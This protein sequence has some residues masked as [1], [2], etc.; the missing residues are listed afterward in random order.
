MSHAEP[1]IAAV[2]PLSVSQL[3]DAERM[4]R[5]RDGFQALAMLAPTEL[6]RW[7][8]ARCDPTMVIE[9]ARR[10]EMP[11]PA[12]PPLTAVGAPPTLDEVEDA[13]REA[14]A[15]SVL[16]KLQSSAPAGMTIERVDTSA[17]DRARKADQTR[18]PFP[19]VLDAKGRAGR[20]RREHMLIG[21]S[22]PPPSEDGRDMWLEMVKAVG[23]YVDVCRI[24]A[25]RD[26]AP[27]G[28]AD[29]EVHFSTVPVYAWHGSGLLDP[30]E[31]GGPT[32][33]GESSLARLL[34]G[35]FPRV[36]TKAEIEARRARNRVTIAR[37]RRADASR[38]EAAER[39]QRLFGDPMI[40][41][42]QLDAMRL[43][44]GEDAE[45]HGSLQ[46]TWSS[47][48]LWEQEA[49]QLVEDLPLELLGLAMLGA[50][51]Q[52]P[53]EVLLD[54]ALWR[55]RKLPDRPSFER[56]YLALS[57]M[58]AVWIPSDELLPILLRAHKRFLE[59]KS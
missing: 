32:A 30:E 58:A 27:P 42:D 13:S 8:A 54:R 31:L 22:L 39:R 35:A 7:L 38:R 23:W 16:R 29:D 59:R 45:S 14:L 37:R 50:P 15:M 48:R 55:L 51:G 5:L 28:G 19:V 43:E 49:S 20:K 17:L 34:L 41:P 12:A 33:T 3:A 40:T 18:L 2:P 36:D 9:A 53:R 24:L 46:L 1:P 6:A 21:L 4:Q 57:A 47:V 52:T 44:I 11:A 26:G 56:C 10:V 25:R